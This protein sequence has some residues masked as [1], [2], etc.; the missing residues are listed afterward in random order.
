MKR[1]LPL[2][3]M[4]FFLFSYEKG[5]DISLSVDPLSVEKGSR[6]DINHQ[7][8]F[9]TE[10]STWIVNPRM[11]AYFDN[12]VD[13]SL[14]VGHRRA[15]FGNLLGCHLFY[16]FSK[17]SP[18]YFHQGGVALE[19]LTPFF[20]YRLNYYHPVVKE[21]VLEEFSYHPHQ[22]M[23]AEA[24][25]KGSR[26]SVA[27]G[28]AYN[29]ST[30]TFSAKGRVMVPY[31]NLVVSAG[32]EMDTSLDLRSF[33]SVGYQLYNL[34]KSRDKVGVGRNNR[35]RFAQQE[36]AVPPLIEGPK[37]PDIYFLDV[38]VEEKKKYPSFEEEFRKDH[39]EDL[40][41]GPSFDSSKENAD[42]SSEEGSSPHASE[43]W[44][45]WFVGEKE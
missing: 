9:P 15:C 18:M 34:P 42:L 32:L 40:V 25:W 28:P 16:D 24:V 33:V 5:L 19:Y 44:Y 8:F 35:V 1:L 37:G 43:S 13:L 11:C 17:H 29:L 7:M 3:L 31:Q 20:D 41:Y 36:V 21:R 23:E 6:I 4:P 26:F 30:Q 38:W 45:D 14:G 2:L 22:W 39:P 10:N 27:A 12:H